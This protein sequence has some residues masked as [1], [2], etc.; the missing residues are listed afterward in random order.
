MINKPSLRKSHDFTWM[1]SRRNAV[2]HNMVASDPV[3]ERLGPRSTPMSTAFATLGG[4]FVVCSADND[5]R[6]RR[7]DIGGALNLIA[8]E[9]A[10]S[11]NDPGSV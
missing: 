3:T 10:H 5:A 11:M 1:P 7:S 9:V 8:Q 4:T 6:P 2:S